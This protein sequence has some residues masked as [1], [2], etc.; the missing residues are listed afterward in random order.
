MPGQL[1][2]NST[3][4]VKPASRRPS[5]Q[6]VMVMIGMAAFL[7]AWWKM[8]ERVRRPRACPTSMCCWPSSSSMA[9]RTIWVVLPS[10]NAA[11][12]IE[13]RTKWEISPNPFVGNNRNLTLSKMINSSPSQNAGMETP[14]SETATAS[15]SHTES[16]R[17]AARTPRGREIASAMIIATTISSSVAGRRSSTSEFAGCC[18][19][20]DWPKSPCR[21]SEMS[22]KN[23][24]GRGRSK[25]CAWEKAWTSSLVA[26]KGN[27]SRAGL[28][29]A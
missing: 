25:P 19:Q 20:Y 8:R 16:R 9:L 24:A 2:T 27:I 7:S 14:S 26:V 13:G 18:C 21:A 15:L 6:P 28:P 29:S 11:S 1:K 23:C 12:V 17:A 10:G 4:T 5:S 22:V 3:R